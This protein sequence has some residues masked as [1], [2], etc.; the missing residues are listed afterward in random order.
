MFALRLRTGRG[1]PQWTRRCQDTE[2]HFSVP[3]HGQNGEHML[4][5]SGLG[6]LSRASLVCTLWARPLL[7]KTRFYRHSDFDD[8]ATYLDQ[9]IRRCRRH[10]G[11]RRAKMGREAGLR[12]RDGSHGTTYEAIPAFSFWSPS[13]GTILR[14]STSAYTSYLACPFRLNRKSLGCRNGI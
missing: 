3:T 1:P 7:E 10:S 12:L 11:E 4:L 8:S 9:S 14:D 6:F 13:F 2:S 5:H